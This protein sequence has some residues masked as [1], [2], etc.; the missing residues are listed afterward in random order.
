M[1]PAAP[2]RFELGREG[3]WRLLSA[4][5]RGSLV[6]LW[7]GAFN[8]AIAALK[9]PRYILLAPELAHDVVRRPFRAIAERSDQ[10]MRRAA[11]VERRDQ[12]LHDRDGAV[13]RARI[14][15]RF[16]KM[17]LRNMP[18][19]QR[20][21]L[22]V[23]LTEVNAKL[24]LVHRIGELEVGRRRVDRIAAEDDQDVDLAAVHVADQVTE[25][26]EVADRLRL[27]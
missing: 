25:R 21:R 1:E 18:M 16:E 14:A 17:R 5:G 4:L 22:I 23:V 19:T 27:R 3:G 11:A 26:I 15:P 13:V 8:P 7:R 2:L 9:G 24:H 20:R 10:F 12:R 6:E